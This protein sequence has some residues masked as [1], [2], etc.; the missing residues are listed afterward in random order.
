MKI[1]R[2]FL[3]ITLV[4]FC[5][6]AILPQNSNT[7]Y[8]VLD[9]GVIN[10]G[11]ILT[12]DSINKLILE[13][14]NNG[15]GIVRF[16]HGTYLSG[17]I[18]LQNN[19]TLQLDFGAIILGAEN[20]IG[21]YESAEENPW[22]EYQDFGH[23]HFQNGLI[24]GIE[25]ENVNIIGQG[26]I[27][28]G[29]ITDRNVVPDGGGDKAISLKHSKNILIDGVRIEQGGH[30]AIIATGCDTLTIRNIQIYTPRDGMNIIASTEVLVE[31]CFVE[32]VLHDEKSHIEE[33]DDAIALKSDYSLGYA[34]LSE[35]ITIRDCVI[36]S[37]GANAFQIGSETAGDF[38]NI[39]VENII[40]LGAE[41]AGI[42][43][44]T[45]DGAVLDGIYI[46][47]ITMRRVATPLFIHTSQRLRTPEKVTPG[48]F[49]NI[50]IKNVTA[51]DVYGYLKHRGPWTATISG[52]KEFPVDNVTLENIH[53]IYKG[54]DAGD[55]EEINPKDPLR[56]YTPRSMERR[57]AY[58]FYLRHA[59]NV[60][61]KNVYLE[62][63]NEDSRPA[64][65]ASD[66]IDFTIDNVYADR[67]ARLDF[68]I[69]LEGVTGFKSYNSEKLIIQTERE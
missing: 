47:N 13:C 11:K 36:R 15:G 9:Y 67:P 26:V 17:T 18:R 65:Y 53:I 34:R 33:G 25:V 64:I 63:E 31:N 42:G 54:I 59:V 46:N 14:S 35:N 38:K 19:V 23:S 24:V 12:T 62:F 44:T 49:K 7:V 58:G 16:P 3:T 10:D 2:I 28:G 66:I 61:M 60:S 57:P 20:N 21:A 8:N 40:I 22:D 52:I 45:N 50:V 37:G 41:K 48:Q 30:F 55:W 29:G 69:F 1:S 43:M 5:D 56:S 68:D 32:A 27:N 6:S 39:R 51:K 4:L